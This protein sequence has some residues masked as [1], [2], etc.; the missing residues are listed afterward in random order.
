MNSL[1][2]RIKSNA[3]IVPAGTGGSVSVFATD[4]TNVILDING[5]FVPVTTA[6]ALDYYPVTPC[7][8]ADTR[9]S[10]GS[11][12]G[13]SLAGNQTRSIPVLSSTCGIPSSAQAYSLNF[14]A[15]PQGALGYLSVWPAGQSQPLVSTL[16]AP[17]GTLTANAAIVPAGSGGAIDLFVT[18]TTNMVIDVNGYFAPAGTGGLSLYTLTPCRVL[19]TRQGGAQPFSGAL[20]VN[21]TAFGCSVPAGAQSYVFNATVVPSGTLGYLT[22]WAQGAA[23]PVVSTLNA[24]DG[25]VTSNMAIVPTTSGPI[26]AYATYPTQL[27]LDISGYF[28]P[29][30][31]PQM[32][33]ISVSA[34]QT[35]SY[36]SSLVN[37]PDEHTTFLPPG[38]LPGAGAGDYL[39]FASSK[40]T[41]STGGAV[42]L[43]TSDLINFSYAT[44]YGDSSEG[45][46]VMWPAVS[47][48]SCDPTYDSLFDENYSAPGSLLQDPTTGN[49][50]MIYEAENH[51]PGDVNQFPFYASIGL[52]VSTD[53]GMT[54]PELVSGSYGPSRFPALQ[55]LGP[56]PSSEATPRNYGDAIPSAYIDTADGTTYL[57][58]AYLYYGSPSSPAT[59]G[60]IR[61]ARAQL[62][63]SGPLTFTKWYQGGFTQPGI[64]GLD[65]GVLPS[66]GCSGFQAQP[67]ISRND[68][69]GVYMMTFVCV[70]VV[71]GVQTEA[72]WFYSTAT[73]LA[74][75]NWSA[76]QMIANSQFAVT[77]P[78]TGSSAGGS[79]F[80]G[81][82]PSLMSPGSPSGHT[83]ATGYVFFMKGCTG[84]LPRVFSSRTFTITGN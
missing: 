34:D 64:A 27:L 62:G 57:Y 15:I 46:H 8:V 38:F 56:E 10:T 63:G 70:T 35:L 65:T 20:N 12:G 16:N 41:G 84:G 30:N 74:L 58:V 80:D 50:L 7:R 44:G 6:G 33:S 72:A 28:A 26:S 37:I 5:Y 79:Q 25:S 3:A 39:V 76:P 83:T 32:A 69:Y 2:G 71:S 75:Q 67:D 60:M 9:N 17:T 55:V 78:C 43:Q 82:Y 53:Q 45:D 31:Q 61:V 51:C 23:Q 52:A 29:S 49:F 59:D 42:A 47:F 11:L 1:D 54:W 68:T 36:P 4:A 13:P 81:W 24:I 77:D 40:T 66:K 19:D 73:S 14:T 18:N 21:V 48:T 22:L